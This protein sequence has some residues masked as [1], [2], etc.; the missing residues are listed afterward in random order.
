MNRLKFKS[1]LVAERFILILT[2][3]ENE[4][5]YI[6]KSDNANMSNIK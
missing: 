6:I 1:Q 4:N 3:H 2:L 5:V